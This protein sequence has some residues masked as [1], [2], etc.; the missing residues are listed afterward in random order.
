M[1]YRKSSHATFDCRYHLVWITKWRNEAIGG[2][3]KENLEKRLRELCAKM[4]VNVLNIGMEDDHVH[5]YISIPPAKSVSYIVNRLKGVTSK[6]MMEKH[7]EYLK[8]WYWAE[9]S[10]LWAR[11]YFVATVGEM[12][13]EV[14]RDYVASQWSEK[15]IEV[16]DPLWESPRL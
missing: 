2:K 1:K 16:E 15:E 8:K 4:Y 3:F 9:E 10:T 14:V 13:A 6:E 12:T 7:K 5:M 11:G